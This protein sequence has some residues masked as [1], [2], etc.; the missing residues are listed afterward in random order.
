MTGPALHVAIAEFEPF[1]LTDDAE[2]MGQKC[3]KGIWYFHYEINGVPHLYGA[4]DTEEAAREHAKQF[5][6]LGDC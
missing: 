4:F 3:P 6:K 5:Q 1:V 2:I